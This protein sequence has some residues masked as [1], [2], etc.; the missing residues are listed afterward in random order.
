MAYFNSYL[1]NETL[2]ILQKAEVMEVLN[3]LTEAE[4]KTGSTMRISM[5]L[6]KWRCLSTPVTVV[7]IP[8][9]LRSPTIRN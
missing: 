3:L 8:T 1:D 9:T 7:V 6:M 4:A 5:K 2:P